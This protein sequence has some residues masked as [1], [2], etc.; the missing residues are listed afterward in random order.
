VAWVAQD[1]DGVWW[2]YEAE[3]LQHA[4][5]WY[6]NEVGRCIRIAGGQPNPDWRNTLEALQ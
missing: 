1:A 2:G 3:P 5:G 6:E 4:S